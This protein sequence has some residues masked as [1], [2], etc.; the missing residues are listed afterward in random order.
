MLWD[1]GGVEGEGKGIAGPDRRSG[2]DS[3][4]LVAR[5]HETIHISPE[6]GSVNLFA[7]LLFVGIIK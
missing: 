6:K 3:G 2:L 1:C 4:L 5:T 7:S